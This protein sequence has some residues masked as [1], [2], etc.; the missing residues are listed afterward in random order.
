[1]SSDWFYHAPQ[2]RRERQV[3][4]AQPDMPPMSQIP[5]LSDLSK[6]EDATQQNANRGVLLRDS[7]SKYIK[8]A[9]M[10]GRKNLLYFTQPVPSTEPKKYPIPEWWGNKNTGIDPAEED[11]AITRPKPSIPDYMVHHPY[12]SKDDMQI[13]SKGRSRIPFGQDGQSHWGRDAEDNVRNPHNIRSIDVSKLLSETGMPFPKYKKLPSFP[14]VHSSATKDGEPAVF[15]KI[16]NYGYQREWLDEREEQR[17]ADEEKRRLYSH[18][19]RNT[20]S[21]KGYSLVDSTNNQQQTQS[22][23]ALGDHKA[24]NG[25]A[26]AASGAVRRY[27][28]SS[29]ASGI[30]PWKTTTKTAHHGPVPTSSLYKMKRFEKVPSRVNAPSVQEV[31]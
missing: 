27:Q 3:Q 17:R 11:M 2:K 29:A 19:L 28:P 1:M 8:L 15:S 30:K 31:H 16:L 13:N 4:D 9:K 25:S 5:G 26:A 22:A 12:L 6:E 23:A 7:D 14:N 21:E 24:S 18:N 10:G 20:L